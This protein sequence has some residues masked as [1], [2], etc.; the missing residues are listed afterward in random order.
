MSDLAYTIAQTDLSN[1]TKQ[2]LKNFVKAIR[3]S[4]G[5]V[6]DAA[7]KLTRPLP[8]PDAETER[9]LAALEELFPLT[10]S[11]PNAHST[12]HCALT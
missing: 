3:E 1:A 6:I 12:L 4:W 5:R 10:T 2:Q 7:R 8:E 11:Q 9:E